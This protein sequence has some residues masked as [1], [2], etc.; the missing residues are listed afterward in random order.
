MVRCASFT[1]MEAVRRPTI[2]PNADRTRTEQRRCPMDRSKPKPPGLGVV[3][4]LFTGPLQPWKRP[5][6]P[7]VLPL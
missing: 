6:A 5:H 3:S 7:A 4:L 1:A 2:T